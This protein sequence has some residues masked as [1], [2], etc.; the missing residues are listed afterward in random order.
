MKLLLIRPNWTTRR[1]IMP[2]LGL[3]YVVAAAQR[4]GHEAVIYDAWL[5]NASPSSAAVCLLSDMYLEAGKRPDIIGVQVYQ[6]TWEWTREF[7]GYI[8]FCHPQIKLIIG[9]PY[10]T[11]LGESARIQMNADAAVLGEF[12][13]DIDEHLNAIMAGKTLIEWTKWIDVNEHPFPD[14][15]SMNLPEYWPYIYSAG[16]PVRGKRV[17]FIQRTRGCPHRCTFCASG[18]IIMGKRVR[19]RELDNV[20]EELEYLIKRWNID[21]LWFQDD[22]VT[23]DYQ[24]GINLFEALVPYKLHVRLQMGIRT[25]HLTREML[26][27]MKKAGVYYAGI[28]I[29]SGNPRVLERIKKGLNQEKVLNGIRILDKNGILVMGFFMFGLPTESR[30]EMEETVQWA[31]KSRL[32]HAQFSIFIPYPG[33]EDYHERS[34]LPHEDLVK[35]QR[36]ATLRFYMRPRIIWSFIRNFRWSQLRVIWNHPWVIAWRNSVFINLEL[37]KER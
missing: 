14:W 22:D 2:P 12:E 33:S 8:R 30:S 9:G 10:T 25:D 20:I 26:Y 23:I 17:G 34:L 27:W 6:N 32:H 24:K 21:E 3:G 16:A 35:V 13:T 11:A 19:F 4:A 7:F 29:E 28:G 1:M 5:K 31:L 18:G 36:A 37:E 15:D